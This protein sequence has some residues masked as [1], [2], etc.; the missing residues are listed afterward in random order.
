MARTGT[1]TQTPSLALL[2]CP[3]FQFPR[4]MEKG[5]GGRELVAGRADTAACQV[6]SYPGRGSLPAECPPHSLPPAPGVMPGRCCWNCCHSLGAAPAHVSAPGDACL[7]TWKGEQS[8]EQGGQLR[9]MAQSTGAVPGL[10]TPSPK[11]EVWHP[12]FSI[13]SK[14]RLHPGDGTN[15]GGVQAGPKAWKVAERPL[16][17]WLHHHR[18]SSAAPDPKTCCAPTGTWPWSIR[19]LFRVLS[20]EPLGSP[21]RTEPL[22]PQRFAAPA[23]LL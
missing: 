10:S 17:P 7:L 1:S 11:R 20:R 8:W 2:L 12:M 18:L 5:Q 3:H 23:S 14:P 21:L 13:L 16:P 6:P 19:T 15:L 22:C 4:D 9:E